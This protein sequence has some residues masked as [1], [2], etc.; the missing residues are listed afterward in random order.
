MLDRVDNLF[1]Q[2]TRL[3]VTS[4]RCNNPKLKKNCPEKLSRESYATEVFGKPLVDLKLVPDILSGARL[5]IFW[6]DMRRSTKHVTAVRHWQPWTSNRAGEGGRRKMVLHMSAEALRGGENLLTAGAL[7][8]PNQVAVLDLPVLLQ[9]SPRVRH[10]IAYVAHKFSLRPFPFLC[11]VLLPTV[12]RMVQTPQSYPERLF[13]LPAAV[14]VPS[15]ADRTGNFLH[16]VFLNSQEFLTLQLQFLLLRAVAAGCLN[17]LLTASFPQG[18][19]S[20]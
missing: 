12:A 6:S 5:L 13:A 16:K 10:L 9:L 11:G 15:Q 2:P 17:T 8:P 4:T 18:S 1:P 19:C 20:P 7:V 14:H 3:P